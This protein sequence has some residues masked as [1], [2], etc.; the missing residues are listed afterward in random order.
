MPKGVVNHQKIITRLSEG[1]VQ[2]ANLLPTTELTSRLYPVPRVRSLVVAI[3]VNILKFLVRALRWYQESKFMHMVHAITRPTELSYD[4]ILQTISSLA[5]SLSDA[6]M[7]SSQAEQR[8]MHL[9]ILRQIQGQE[10]LQRSLDSQDALIR[11][12]GMAVLGACGHQQDLAAELRSLIIQGQDA[13]REHISTVLFEALSLKTRARAMHD[14]AQIDMRQQLSAAQ[15]AEALEVIAVTRL[16]DPAAAHQTSLLLANKRR[17]RPSLRGPPFWLED[18]FQQWN[19]TG[20]PSLVIIDGIRKMRFHLQWFSAKSIALLREAGIPAVWVLKT[21]GRDSSDAMSSVDIIKYLIRQVVLLNKHMHTDSSMSQ[22]SSSFSRARSEEDWIDI[23]GL[24]LQG[25][26]CLYIVLDFEILSQAGR[27][28]GS[29]GW[30]AVFSGLFEK[31]SERNVKTVVKVALV[32]Y[33]SPLLKDS[34]NDDYGD[35]VV[36]VGRARQLNSVLLRRPGRGRGVR[37]SKGHSMLHVTQITDKTLWS[38]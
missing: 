9:E 31:L 13:M 35:C 22:C 33:S 21:V 26:P 17:V 20:K 24:V 27:S 8:D 16:S 4:D 37:S 23:L 6:A 32:S 19:R 15:V 5:R 1:L 18:K 30:P 12:V 2:I 11:Q 25:L 38:R 7:V 10:C 3:Y 34:L 28:H 14:S 36:T 29:A